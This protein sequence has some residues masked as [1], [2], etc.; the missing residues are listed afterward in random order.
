MH[1]AHVAT[2]L[3]KT[4]AATPHFVTFAS[5]FSCNFL[6][7]FSEMALWALPKIFFRHWLLLLKKKNKKNTILIYFKYSFSPFLVPDHFQRYGFSLSL[8]TLI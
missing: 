5:R 1:S 3:C 4:S 8:L 6:K 7:W 2:T